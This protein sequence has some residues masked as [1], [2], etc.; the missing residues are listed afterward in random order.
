MKKLFSVS[1]IIL[2]FIILGCSG[3]EK[4]QKLNQQI[5][6]L[7]AE[8]SFDKALEKCKELLKEYP[9]SPFAMKARL[10]IGKFYH[11]K[12]ISGISAENQY[13]LA[14]DTYLEVYNNYPD[15]SDTPKALF[16]AGFL[17]ANEL[18]MYD[19]AKVIYEKFVKVY[20]DNE[21]SEHVKYELQNIGLTPDQ[22]LKNNQK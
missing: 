21:L 19:S 1:F 2:L 12:A 14:V 18:K 13:R 10:E 15:S 11:S 16:Y 7:I 8:K 6:K 3:V 20:P 5:D 4:D 17:L 22:I 9:A